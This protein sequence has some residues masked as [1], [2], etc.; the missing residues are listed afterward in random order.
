MKTKDFQLTSL[1][2]NIS[3]KVF[4]L[5]EQKQQ[6]TLLLNL[7][8]LQNQYMNPIS[9]QSGLDYKPYRKV[10]SNLSSARVK[11]PL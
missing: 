11:F 7:C 5:H 4:T 3:T 10:M 2:E 8:L 1:F 6:S 9:T